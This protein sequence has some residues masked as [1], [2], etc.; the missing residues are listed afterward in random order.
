MGHQKVVASCHQG[1]QQTFIIVGRVV[2]RSSPRVNRVIKKVVISC[3]NIHH[4][5]TKGSHVS[6]KIG[7]VIKYCHLSSVYLA[8]SSHME[9][10]PVLQCCRNLLKSLKV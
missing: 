2:N 3:H 1:Y 6:K 9:K 8:K 5:V 4:M 7:K 10:L